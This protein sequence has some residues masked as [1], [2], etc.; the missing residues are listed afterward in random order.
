MYGLRSLY[1]LGPIGDLD[2]LILYDPGP[3]E[4]SLIKGFRIDTSG[5]GD[6]RRLYYIALLGFLFIFI[7]N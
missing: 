7:K 2:I 4:L 1:I 3:G 5:I 6:F